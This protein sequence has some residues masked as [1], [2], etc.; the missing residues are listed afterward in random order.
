MEPS[1]PG[2][3]TGW[4][5]GLRDPIVGRALSAIHSAPVDEWS[6]DSLARRAGASRSVLAERFTAVVA[7][8]RRWW[9]SR[10]LRGDGTQ[11]VGRRAR[12]LPLRPDTAGA[13]RRVFPVDRLSDRVEPHAAAGP[14]QVFGQTPFRLNLTR[15]FE[16]QDRCVAGQQ[17][18]LKTRGRSATSAPSRSSRRYME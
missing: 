16:A 2:A 15:A 7:R 11:R 12:P 5:A 18:I 13:R 9:V 17:M 14:G 8:S 10:P 4:L 1:S 3:Q 6:V